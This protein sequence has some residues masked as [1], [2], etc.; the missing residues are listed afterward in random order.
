MRKDADS[1]VMPE[2]ST[3]LDLARIGIEEQH[4][5]VGVVVR[6]RRELSIVKDIPVLFAIDQVHLNQHNLEI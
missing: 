3:L 5:A 6:L 2:D 4:A 1:M